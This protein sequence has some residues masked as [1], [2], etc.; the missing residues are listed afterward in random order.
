MKLDTMF[1]VRCHCGLVKEFEHEMD[2]LH[3][4][5]RH[6][7]RKHK[8]LYRRIEKQG[9]EAAKC[10]EGCGYTDSDW[11]TKRTE[12]TFREA[13]RVHALERLLQYGKAR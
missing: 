8:R 13:W 7:R 1:T 2:A 3:Y 9:R 10:Q 12:P 5:L 11:P 6:I 4:A